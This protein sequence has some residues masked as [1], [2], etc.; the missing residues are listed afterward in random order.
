MN[1]VFEESYLEIGVYVGGNKPRRD[2]VDIANEM[3]FRSLKIETHVVNV[4]KRIDSLRKMLFRPVNYFAWIRALKQLRRGDTVL[5]QIPL[6][7]DLKMI[8][9]FLSLTRK[10]GVK[11]VAILHDLM[12]LQRADRIEKINLRTFKS[13]CEIRLLKCCD[14]IIVH[15]AK[16]KNFMVDHL[17]FAGDRLTVLGIFDYLSDAADTGKITNNRNSVVFAGNLS[18]IKSGF[19]YNLPPAPE[20]EL[21]GVNYQEKEAK[22]N[23]C[24]HGAFPPEKLAKVLSGGYGLVW[25]GDSCSS[26]RGSYG[27]YLKYNNPHKTSLYLSLGLPVIIWN[28]AALADFILEHKCGIAVQSLDELSDVLQTVDASRYAEMKSAVETMGAKLRKG[29]YTRRALIECLN[30]LK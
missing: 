1:W 11:I 8:A 16:M 28:K 7:V 29:F 25:D 27:T 13:R 20:F 5:L 9:P 26:C 14:R 30:D 19:L 23:V 2:F 17:G 4:T 21:Y 15:N 22:R 24:Y 12:F 18:E 3:G 6:I 10:R